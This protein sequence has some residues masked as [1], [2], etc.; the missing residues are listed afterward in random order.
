MKAEERKHLVTNSLA[1]GLSNLME[2][3]KQGPSRRT[4]IV[5]GVIALAVALFFTWRYFSNRAEEKS[6]AR[7]LAW[8]TM[9]DPDSL[10][11]TVDKLAEENKRP[12][13]GE[14][15]EDLVTAAQL[16]AFSAAKDNEGTNQG[17]QARVD[18]A[19]RRLYRG[20][21][22][23]GV[24]TYRETAREDLTNCAEEYVKL[25]GEA[26]DSPLLQQEAFLNA[27]K[28]YEALGE[29]DKARK[30]YEALAK[31]EHE[32]SAAGVEA[33]RLLKALNDPSNEG[34]YDA[35]ANELKK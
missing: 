12:R 29:Y 24:P 11:P 19:R 20:T 13:P 32:K 7:T 25:Q 27:G 33:A 18:L 4:L 1:Q 22:L 8:F 9:G 17:R 30:N 2:K 6:S 23:L 16:Q 15:W 28:A 26:S 3:A 21:L 14:R 35:L 34:D 10:R 31:K 5:V